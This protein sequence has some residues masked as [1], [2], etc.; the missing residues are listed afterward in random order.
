MSLKFAIWAGAALLLFAAETMAPGAFMLWF[1]FAATAMAVVVLLLPELGWLWQAILFSVFAVISVGIYLK[2][3]RGR[4]RRSDQPLLNRR[5]EQ[6]IGRVL[7]LDQAIA[8]GLGRVK[9]DDAFWSVSGPDLPVG[10]RV[11]VIA[12]DG[13]VLKVQAH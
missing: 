4:G 5:A 8:G 7:E 2:W 10:T 12:V 6:L 9:V 13:M 1:G 3:F 11:R